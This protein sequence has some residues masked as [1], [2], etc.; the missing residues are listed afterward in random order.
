[1]LPIFKKLKE[2][3]GQDGVIVKERAPDQ[4]NE[5]DDYSPEECAKDLIQSV[6]SNDA[7]GVVRAMRDLIENLDN[8]SEESKP[9]PHSYEAQN[10]QAGEE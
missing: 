10:E 9:S 3:S 6:H 7:A 5:S 1:M 4:P 8:D 2:K